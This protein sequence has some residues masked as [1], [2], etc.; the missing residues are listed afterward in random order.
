VLSVV[1]HGSWGAEPQW[2]HI[3]IRPA[4]P[5]QYPALVSYDGREEA[6]RLPAVG[7]D[8]P[9]GN[10]EVVD[11]SLWRR[12][13]EATHVTEGL[14]MPGDFLSGGDHGVDAEMKC[15]LAEKSFE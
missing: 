5:L 1:R 12:V 11:G 14:R 6:C 3:A 7:E 15:R 9:P 10:L 8:L 13:W 4:G 2:A